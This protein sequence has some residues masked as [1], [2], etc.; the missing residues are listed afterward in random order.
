M[1]QSLQDDLS[2][3]V[4]E[5]ARRQARDFAKAQGLLWLGILTSVTA[6]LTA[7][8]AFEMP[9]SISA[10][11]AAIPAA[12]I[13]IDKTFKY[14]ARSSWHALYTVQIRVL[15]REL[16]DQNKS[17]EQVSEWLSALDLEMHNL[18]PPLEGSAI[19]TKK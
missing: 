2:A 10:V 3:A 6:S 1:T 15:Q 7:A 14:A 5:H 4:K 8:K 16:R 13:I 9:A 11:I 19:S 12:A 18:F 17:P